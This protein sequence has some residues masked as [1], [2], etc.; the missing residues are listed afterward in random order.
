MAPIGWHVPTIDDWRYLTDVW[1][2][3]TTQWE[4]GEPLRSKEDYVTI[5]KYIDVGGYYEKIVCSKCDYF[6]PEQRNFHPCDNCRNTQRVE[7]GKFI[8]KTKKKVEE[9][10]NL[11]WNG[12]N[13]SGFSALPGGYLDEN[14]WGYWIGGYA[15]WWSLEVSSRPEQGFGGSSYVMCLGNYDSWLPESWESGRSV[16]CIKD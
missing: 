15:G 14:G 4:G 2:I 8:P 3:N 16:R 7:T 5:V 11:G 1:D 10:I 6:T 12:T 9:K 13:K